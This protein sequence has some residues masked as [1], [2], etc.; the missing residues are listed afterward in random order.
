VILLYSI[1]MDDDDIL[2][3]P[4]NEDEKITLEHLWR[5]YN[6]FK[7]R[8]KRQSKYNCVYAKTEK[9]KAKYKEQ[10]QKKKARLAEENRIKRENKIVVMND[11]NY[12]ISKKIENLE[13]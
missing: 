12:D 1:T 10:Y 3:N 7:D 2:I 8:K 6:T 9:G 4:E 5:M 13:I 11:S